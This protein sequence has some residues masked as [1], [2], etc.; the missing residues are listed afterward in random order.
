MRDGFELRK[1]TCEALT[2][3]LSDFEESITPCTFKKKKEVSNGKAADVSFLLSAAT[4][5]E[6]AENSSTG[7]GR[8]IFKRLRSWECN[9]TDDENKDIVCT[10]K[11][12]KLES[13]TLKG[14]NGN[15]KGTRHNSFRRGNCSL[16]PHFSPLKVTVTYQI[17]M[18][19]Q[20]KKNMT[21][22]YNSLGK[23]RSSGSQPFSI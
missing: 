4:I 14:G 12:L 3:A 16:S 21:I 7:R 1:L 10:T 23:I 5:I 6:T 8:I 17:K 18:S 9:L 13:V 22:E 11:D 2:S 19:A 15:H 20:A